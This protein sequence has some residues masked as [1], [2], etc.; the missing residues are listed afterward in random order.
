MRNALQDLAKAMDDTRARINNAMDMIDE[1][2][3]VKSP[4]NYLMRIFNR[5]KIESDREGLK[6]I[7]MNWYRENPEIIVKGDDNLF[8]RQQL[9]TDPA[10]VERIANETI[11]NILGE[12]DEDAVDAIFT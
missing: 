9:A 11:D 6:N 1:M 12:T 10:S 3:S 7:L 8:K 2:P 4:S 5:R